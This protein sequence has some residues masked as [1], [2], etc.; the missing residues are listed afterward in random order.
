MY[1]KIPLDRLTDLSQ[2]LIEKMKYN[3]IKHNQVVNAR[4]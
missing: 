3:T 4:V 2:I 1:L